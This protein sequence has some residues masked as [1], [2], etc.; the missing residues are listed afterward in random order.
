MQTTSRGFTYLPV[1]DQDCF[2]WGGFAI[3]DYCNAPVASGYLVLVL[4]SC[5]CSECFADW[6]KRQKRYKK[7]DVKQDLAY[8]EAY[9]DD[10]YGYHINKMKGE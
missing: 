1:S 3:C 8:Q 6:L 4:N 7:A 5:V 2:S 10:W 9:Q